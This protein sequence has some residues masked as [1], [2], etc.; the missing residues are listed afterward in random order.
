MCL[1]KPMTNSVNRRQNLKFSKKLRIG[2]RI[3][4]EDQRFSMELASNETAVFR[5]IQNKP[6]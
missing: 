6:A 5:G 2:S 3:H 4:Q 1:W